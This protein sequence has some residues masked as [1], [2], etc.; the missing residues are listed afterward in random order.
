MDLAKVKAAARGHPAMAKV[1]T[2]TVVMATA[3][4]ATAVVAFR[5]S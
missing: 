4:V 2:A 3:A 1:L 5:N